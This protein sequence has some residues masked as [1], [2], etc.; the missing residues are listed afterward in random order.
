MIN[1]FGY[2]AA[3][4]RYQ[5]VRDVVAMIESSHWLPEPQTVRIS[6]DDELGPEFT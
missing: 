3:P 4:A 5:A 2:R 1:A 6:S